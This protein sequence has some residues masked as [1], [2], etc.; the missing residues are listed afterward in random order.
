MLEQMVHRKHIWLIPN[1]QTKHTFIQS[2]II[3]SVGLFPA[4]KVLLLSC[5]PPS[6]CSIFGYHPI[7]LTYIGKPLQFSVIFSSCC[8][9]CSINC[10]VLFLVSF[11]SQMRQVNSSAAIHLPAT[12]CLHSV[13]VPFIAH[14]LDF[15]RQKFMKEACFGIYRQFF[16]ILFMLHQQ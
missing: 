16:S 14:T 9:P 15:L 2:K 10:S 12:Q 8:I 5:I 1:A 11:S 6:L 4:I 13:S 3:I 7:I